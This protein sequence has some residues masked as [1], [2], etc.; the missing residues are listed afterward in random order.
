LRGSL[1]HSVA[2]KAL[3]GDYINDSLPTGNGIQGG[4]FVDYFRVRKRDE[5]KPP[6]EQFKNF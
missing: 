3:D 2:G 4:D 1:I 6:V 5:D